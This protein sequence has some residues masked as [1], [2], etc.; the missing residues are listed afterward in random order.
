MPSVSSFAMCLCFI[1]RRIT[2]PLNGG[3]YVFA[4]CFPEVATLGHVE[5]HT[6]GWHSPLRDWC[7]VLRTAHGFFDSMPDLALELLSVAVVE[8]ALAVEEVALE[9]SLLMC[10]VL[11]QNRQRFCLKQAVT[12]LV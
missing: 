3:L 2:L 12:L 8:Q 1:S 10:P 11:L 5:A 4:F 7:R 6:G 9:H